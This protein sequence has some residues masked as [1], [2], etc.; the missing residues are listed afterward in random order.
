VSRLAAALAET[1]RAEGIRT[2]FF[3]GIDEASAARSMEHV[4]RIFE[5]AH[6]A[7][8]MRVGRRYAQDRLSGRRIDNQASATGRRSMK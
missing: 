5:A 7:P 8:A 3:F 4:T 2:E 6:R 1:I